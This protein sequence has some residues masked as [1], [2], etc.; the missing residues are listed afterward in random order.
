MKKNLLIILFVT[1]CLFSYSEKR[2]LLVGI[3]HY[4]KNSGWQEISSTND[5]DLLKAMFSAYNLQILLDEE[6]THEK[7]KHALKSLCNSIQKG[8]TILIHFSC[9]GQQMLPLKDNREVDKLDE[10]LVPYDAHSTCS[11]AYDGR[12]HLRDDEMGLLID[13]I[14][15]KAGSDGLVLLT[16]DACFSDSMNKGLP[17]TKDKY[18]GGADIFGA[19][20]IS[21]D[22]L[23]KLLVDRTKEEPE[24]TIK[25]QGIADILILS[26]CKSYQRNKEVVVRG[27]GFGSLSY[28][29]YAS[30]KKIGLSNLYKWLDGIYEQMQEL[31]FTQTPQIRTTLGYSFP[32]KK[33]SKKHFPNKTNEVTNEC[34]IRTILAF[35]SLIGLT[36]L[37]FLWLKLKRKL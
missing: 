33:S 8:D 17:K 20:N 22:S 12:N 15:K 6:A 27:M 18:R 30:Y 10:A 7:I 1:Q 3:G 31:A 9:H 4:P 25:K 32:A 28:A 26:A 35:S 23:N 29:M 13:S 34:H 16:I 14:R 21:K 5:I 19:N 11:P 2:V 37:V 36:I 24:T